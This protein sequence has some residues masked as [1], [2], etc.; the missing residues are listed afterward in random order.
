VL[1]AVARKDGV[2]AVVELDRDGDDQ[3]PLR[4][5]QPLHDRVADVRIRHRLLELRDRLVEER[6]LPLERRA[7]LGHLVHT[8]HARSVR[9]KVGNEGADPLPVERKVPP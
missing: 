1:D 4:D 6:S 8:R 2:A 7:L 5:A 9:L 3:R